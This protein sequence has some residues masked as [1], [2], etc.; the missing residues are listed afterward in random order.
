MALNDILVA[1]IAVSAVAF[2]YQQRK[3]KGLPLPPGPK[4]LPVL[5][6]LRDLA[7]KTLWFPATRWAK[8]FGSHIIS[9]IP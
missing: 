4:G 3:G 9:K 5:G 8:E 6:N 7:V 1:V 2:V